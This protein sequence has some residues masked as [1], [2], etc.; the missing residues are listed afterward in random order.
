[1]FH[2]KHSV[3]W[4]STESMRLQMVQSDL[5]CSAHPKKYISTSLGRKRQVIQEC[6]VVF[7]EL[8]FICTVYSI[9]YI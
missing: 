6:I 3:L 9:L 7:T 8:L 4:I 1:M 2:G 5:E